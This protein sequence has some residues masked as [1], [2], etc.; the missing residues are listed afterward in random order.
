MGFIAGLLLPYTYW[1]FFFG[2]ILVE[3]QEGPGG[4]GFSWPH[5]G[6]WTLLTQRCCCNGAM[7]SDT[8]IHS[9]HIQYCTECA[10]CQEGDSN[11]L[12]SL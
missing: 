1:L 9:F 3:V 10:V 12:S 8:M 7:D 5:K 6:R 4:G 11:R 2:V